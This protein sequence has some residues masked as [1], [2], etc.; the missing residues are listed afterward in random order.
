MDFG[1]ELEKFL[2]ESKA[3]GVVDDIAAQALLRFHSGRIKSR[4]FSMVSAALGGIGG[5]A[6]VFGIILVISSNWSG[7][8]PYIKIAGFLSL[9]ASVHGGALYLRQTHPGYEKTRNAL[10][11]VGAGLVLA[12]IGLFAQIYHLTSTDGRAFLIWFLLILPL[13]TLILTSSLT[14]LCLAAFT[15]WY[16]LFIYR[17]S[18]SYNGNEI[19]FNE[20]VLGCFL[21]ALHVIL[22]RF[23]DEEKFGPSLFIGGAL[24][25]ALV[26]GALGFEHEIKMLYSSGQ[27]FLSGPLTLVMSAVTAL[28]ALYIVAAAKKEGRSS[29]LKSIGAVILAAMLFFPLFVAN[30]SLWGIWTW[31]VWISVLSWFFWFA[32][33]LWLILYGAQAERRAMVSAG[34]WLLGVGIILRFLDLV[35]TMLTTGI[36]FIAFGLAL[37]TIC[38]FVEK[39]RRRLLVRIE[40]VK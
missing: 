38:Y 7:I 14:L 37:I 6:V 31:G 16:H 20:T 5:L 34:V 28:S 40:G 29:L 25:L 22:A 24:L 13:A 30:L 23:E 15:I 18:Y 39:F 19:L 9:L 8:P 10:H 4:K 27:P 21:I 32:A 2:S 11:F 26:Y 35:S 17:Q 36:S 1:R 12:G 3:A 33:S